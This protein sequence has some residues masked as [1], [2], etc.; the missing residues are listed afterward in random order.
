MNRFAATL[1]V[2]GLSVLLSGACTHRN[3]SATA[4][5]LPAIAPSTD[6]GKGV[7]ALAAG[8]IDDTFLVAGGANFP[9]TPAAEGGAKRFYDEIFI[10]GEGEWL[11]AGRLSQPTAYG[12][13]FALANRM[14]IAGGA[15]AEGSVDAVV[16]ITLSKSGCDGD[17][18]GLNGT[19]VIISELPPLPLPL[20]QAAAAREGSVLCVAGGLSNGVPS[21]GV[22]CCDL[23]E[24]GVWSKTGELPEAMVQPIAALFGGTLYVWGGFD[25][26]KKEAADYGYRLQEGRWVRIA[27]LP[28]GGTA[29]GATAVQDAEGRMWVAG[30]VNRE[31]FNRALNLAPEQNAEYLSQPVER[32]R[33]RRTL[34]CFDPATERWTS[35]GEYDETARAGAAL[36][37]DRD[38]KL[39]IING[40]L[41][42]G[43]R[44]SES[45]VINVS[46]TKNR[47]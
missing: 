40:E 29:T 36:V 1:L 24:G 11:P 21:K 9:D 7:S 45:A 5:P 8:K 6:Y 20:E 28:D 30:G 42:P 13:S 44:S 33:F 22:Y 25:P 26:V 39:A 10:L 18:D 43:I 34:Y 2:S 19:F 27:G 32:Y 35:A 4:E 14:V 16:Q 12:A 38:G 15:N 46:K 3:D 17:C 31:I 23:A 37:A 41:K 47:Q